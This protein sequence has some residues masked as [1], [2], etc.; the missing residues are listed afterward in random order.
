GAAVE[1]ALAADAEQYATAASGLALVDPARL[2]SVTGAVV[3]GLL[4]ELHPGGLTGD[5]VADVLRG[6]ALSAL[7]LP[8]LDPTVLLVVVTGALGLLDVDDQPAALSPVA[9]VRHAPVLVA[10]L[11]TRLGGAPLAPRLDAALAELRRAETVELP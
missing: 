2:S 3:R 1:A 5:D 8:D 6:C 11:L 7:W 9:V 4:E 10:S